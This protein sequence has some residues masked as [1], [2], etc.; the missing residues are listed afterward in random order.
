MILYPL[1]LGTVLD[2]FENLSVRNVL[3]HQRVIG[4]TTICC[5][6]LH[7]NTYLLSTVPAVG[8]VNVQISVVRTAFVCSGRASETAT[9][10]PRTAGAVAVLMAL[11]ATTVKLSLAASTVSRL[12]ST[13]NPNPTVATTVAATG[14]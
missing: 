7:F 2:G 9:R 10:I 14:C 11:A 4:F 12:L 3:M 5:I 1:C 6:N 8:D 13:H